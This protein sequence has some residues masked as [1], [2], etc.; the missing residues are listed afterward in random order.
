MS[1]PRSL[2]HYNIY[3]EVHYNGKNAASTR[4]SIKDYSPRK[5]YPSPWASGWKP[6]ILKIQEKWNGNWKDRQSENIHSCFEL[7]P[8]FH[9]QNFVL[10]CKIVARIGTHS[11]CLFQMY[12]LFGRCSLQCRGLWDSNSVHSLSHALIVPETSKAKQGEENDSLL[13]IWQDHSEGL[14]FKPT[15]NC[16]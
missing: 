7:L 8:A 2:F 13:V 14:I 11:R 3:L 5:K 6:C 12:T 4:T 16:L 15:E 10:C 9:Q 1:C